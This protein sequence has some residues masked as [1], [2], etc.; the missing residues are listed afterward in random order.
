MN[1]SKLKIL[2][3]NPPRIGSTGIATEEA[4]CKHPQLDLIC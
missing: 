2:T 1:D 3:L 4:A